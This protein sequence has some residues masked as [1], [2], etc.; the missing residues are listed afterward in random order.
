MSYRSF[1]PLVV[2]LMTSCAS[3][4]QNADVDYM[5]EGVPG[6]R[7]ESPDSDVGGAAPCIYARTGNT[8]LLWIPAS[9]Q[10]GANGVYSQPPEGQKFNSV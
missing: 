7:L 5:V 3:P 8:N 6:T 1:L 9:A 4:S 10:L 2:L